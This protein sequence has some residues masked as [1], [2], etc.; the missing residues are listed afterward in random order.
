MLQTIAA[1][2]KNP[3]KFIPVSGVAVRSATYS[4]DVVY[5]LYVAFNLKPDATRPVGAQL[6]STGLEPGATI[7]N[8]G[9]SLHTSFPSSEKDWPELRAT[10][11]AWPVAFDCVGL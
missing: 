5:V 11:E 10:D 9:S 6:V 2:A 8:M 1:G 7:Y 3:E 4:R